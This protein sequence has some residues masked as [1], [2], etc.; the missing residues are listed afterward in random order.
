[1]AGCALQSP[2][3]CAQAHAHSPTTPATPP[4][5][6][7]C[8]NVGGPCISRERF[9]QVVFEICSQAPPPAIVALSEFKPTGA[10]IHEFEWTAQ[11]ASNGNYYLQHSVD[12]EGKNG[13][14]LLIHPD[15]APHGPPICE[16]LLPFRIL[17][18]RAKL[19]SATD[20]PPVSFV[21]VYGSNVPKERREIANALAPL[22]TQPCLIFGDLNGI[23]QWG[24]VEGVSAAYAQRLVWPWLQHHEEQGVLVDFMRQAYQGHPQKRE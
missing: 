4:L 1:M 20:I 14:A 12:P 5:R 23:S 22:L 21:A 18:Y 6:V 16:V 2:E 11:S 24:D 17:L 3:P 8:Y 19:H 9:A 13:I 10:A 7:A 15:L